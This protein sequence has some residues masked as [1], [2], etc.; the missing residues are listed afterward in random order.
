MPREGDVIVKAFSRVERLNLACIQEFTSGMGAIAEPR[1][2]QPSFQATSP[3]SG[4][5][6]YLNPDPPS[7][8]VKGTDEMAETYAA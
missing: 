7:C 2:S 5:C 8:K 1:Q 4:Q 3:H 6:S